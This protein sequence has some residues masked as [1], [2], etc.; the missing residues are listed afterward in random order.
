MP[1]QHD[2]ALEAPHLLPGN[3]QYIYELQNVTGSPTRRSPQRI[4]HYYDC[5][6]ASDEAEKT[7]VEHVDSEAD[8][9]SSSQQSL[10]YTSSEEKAVVK[11]FDRRLVL[12]IACLYMLG[13][14]DRS[15]T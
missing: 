2:P 1:I 3:H 8:Q 6:N 13:F 9:A 12:F 7:V 4:R 10:H 5:E 15:S 14:L 11:K